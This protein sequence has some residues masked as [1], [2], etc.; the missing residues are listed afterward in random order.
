MDL[1][2]H[3]E[4]NPLYNKVK[5]KMPVTEEMVSRKV[6]SLHNGDVYCSSGYMDPNDFTSKFSARALYDYSA[7]REDELSFKRGAVINNVQQ[8]AYND[9]NLTSTF[10][11]SFV[12]GFLV[13]N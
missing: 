11:F 2:S 7:R 6:S 13:Q 5:L 10:Q 8:Q 1:I 3:Y 4:R 9:L 12:D